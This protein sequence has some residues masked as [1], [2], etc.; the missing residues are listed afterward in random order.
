METAFDDLYMQK[1]EETRK[2]KIPFVSLIHQVPK[3]IADTAQA[4]GVSEK[5]LANGIPSGVLGPSQIAHDRYL[6]FMDAVQDAFWVASLL[7]IF[8]FVSF[9]LFTGPVYIAAMLYWI[10]HVYW[11]E[12]GRAWY[13]KTSVIKYINT[14]YRVYWATFFLAA[15]ALIGGYI[16]YFVNTAIEKSVE[17]I[18]NNGLHIV[19]GAEKAL[20]SSFPGKGF[21]ATADYYVKIAEHAYDMRFLTGLGIFLL[22]TVVVKFWFA[23]INKRDRVLNSESTGAELEYAGET[24]QRALRE[25]RESR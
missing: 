23:R 14:T 17:K 6:S 25:L 1:K 5:F 9:N 2:E 24:A 19:S 21:S 3:Q 11:W 10:V 7:V 16:Y 15:S 18:I 13:L 4:V 8:P 12:K 22:I 20:A